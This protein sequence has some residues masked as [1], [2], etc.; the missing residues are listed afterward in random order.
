MASLS[1][2]SP[3]SGRSSRSRRGCRW[4]R[5]FSV[6]VPNFF[7]HQWTGGESRGAWVFFIFAV[8][9][10][11]LADGVLTSDEILGVATAP[12]SFP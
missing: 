4:R 9:G 3:I 8:K 10:G 2:A 1:V 11:T 6:T 7:P 12:F 5:P